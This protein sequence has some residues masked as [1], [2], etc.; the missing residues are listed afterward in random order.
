[1]TV[2]NSSRDE[3]AHR[4]FGRETDSLGLAIGSDVQ[5]VEKAGHAVVRV[6]VG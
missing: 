2:V 3:V 1:M 6:D 5:A 4:K